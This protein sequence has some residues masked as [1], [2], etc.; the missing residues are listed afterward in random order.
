MCMQILAL[1]DRAQG[2]N[3]RL[4]RMENLLKQLEQVREQDKEEIRQAL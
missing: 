2:G 3:E 1:K 4:R